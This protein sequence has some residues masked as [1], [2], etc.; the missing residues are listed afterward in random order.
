MGRGGTLTYGVYTNGENTYIQEAS[1]NYFVYG[2][3]YFGQNGG[4]GGGY[5][6][7]TSANS[8]FKTGLGG[9]PLK[10]SYENMTYAGNYGGAAYNLRY[11]QCYGGGGGGGG[12]IGGDATSTVGGKGGGGYTWINGSY[13]GGGGGGVGKI[14][15][16]GGG[17][18]GG[19]NTNK[20]GTNGTQNTGGGGGGG[21][22]GFYGGTGGSGILIFAFNIGLPITSGLN[23][24]S[25][26]NYITNNS[27]Q[28]YRFICNAPYSIGSQVA[29]KNVNFS[30]VPDSFALPDVNGNTYTVNAYYG[31]N[32]VSGYSNR[33]TALLSIPSISSVSSS[34]LDGNIIFSIT[35]IPPT[36]ASLYTYNN[37]NISPAPSS[38]PLFDYSSNVIKLTGGFLGDTSYNFSLNASYG[39]AGNS[40]FS[41]QTISRYT[42][43][44]PTISSISSSILGG[45]IV[46]S[47]ASTKP[48]GASNYTLTNVNITPAPSSTPLFSYSGSAI[49]L[50]G[51]FLGDTSYNFKLNASYVSIGTS[52]YSNV[53]TGRYF[54]GTTFGSI[55]AVKYYPF[56]TNM[57]NYA[58]GL[59]VSD[60]T[61][62]T[63]T[64]GGKHNGTI[65]PQ[66]LA[67]TYTQPFIISNNS[68]YNNSN[69]MQY[70]VTSVALPPIKNQIPYLNG[71]I[72]TITP[73]NGCTICFWIKFNDLSY[74]AIFSIANLD[75]PYLYQPGQSIVYC[76]Q[77]NNGS[78]GKLTAGY[79]NV[80]ATGGNGIYGEHMDSLLQNTT[81][82]VNTYVHY[83]ISINNTGFQKMYV[84]GLL[85]TS[86]NIFDTSNKFLNISGYKLQFFVGV[87]G[88]PDY[89]PD[90][91]ICNIK[92]LYIYNGVLSATDITSLYNKTI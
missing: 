57:L 2:G 30:G 88:F 32:M 14:G 47:F 75:W 10:I 77:Q 67:T 64:N 36:S 11:R 31:L 38:T 33:V 72:P 23:T 74:G 59:G 43:I 63:P 49:T 51:G 92:E 65:S 69:W 68:L 89:Y 15:G 44:A 28:Y 70:N 17:G 13:Y 50:T 58:S 42:M 6:G 39:T 91:L 22:P 46:F 40:A 29:L 53:L 25:I 86:K 84:N 66:S 45:D 34:A 82:N 81:F 7:E 56:K 60:L 83:A 41:L 16:T 62:V 21:Y 4:S 90:S 37:L 73:Y 76:I 3:G 52:S 78:T 80:Y 48:T 20:T 55:V 12:E 9:E 5:S 27:Y 79:N 24:Y 85:D 18:S 26:P 54:I 19:N 1:N 35:S 87:T 71:T 61:F 8:E